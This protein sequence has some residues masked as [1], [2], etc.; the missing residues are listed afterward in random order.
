MMRNLVKKS[1]KEKFAGKKVCYNCRF[2]N[3]GGSNCRRF[4]EYA[5]HGEADWC[6]EHQPRTL[7]QAIGL[8]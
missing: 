7:D 8:E 6:G 2:Y 4:P 5:K 3:H 1:E